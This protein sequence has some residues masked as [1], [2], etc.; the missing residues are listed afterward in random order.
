MSI[1]EYYQ[2]PCGQAYCPVCRIEMR[3][4]YPLRI[5]TQ[6]ECVCEYAILRVTA[7]GLELVE[8][9]PCDYD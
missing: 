8:T 7:S 5:D 9:A 1:T 6:H 2:A 3:A 4:E